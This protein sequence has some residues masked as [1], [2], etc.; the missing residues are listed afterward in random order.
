MIDQDFLPVFKSH[1]FFA[2]VEAGVYFNGGS[3]RTFILQGKGLYPLVSRLVSAMDGKASVGQLAGILP[4][5]AQP[6]FWNL[7]GQLTQRNLL[8]DFRAARDTLPAAYW[9]HYGETLAY[10]RDNVPDFSEA[11]L[12][13][14]GAPI[15]VAGSGYAF[16]ALVRA[17]ARSGVARLAILH[18][19]PD[20][21]APSLKEIT[22]ALE[23][24]AAADEEFR[25]EMLTDVR[26]IVDHPG[27]VVYAADDVDTA[28]PGA[29]LS[30]LLAE[31]PDRLL[32][33]GVAD[34]EGFVGPQ[35]VAGGG[36]VQDL[37]D[38]LR[39]KPDAIPHS[40]TS[41]SVIGN[42]LALETMRL[43]N[44]LARAGQNDDRARLND[45]WL[46]VSP[47][48]EILLRPAPSAPRRERPAPAGQKFTPPPLA[49]DTQQ[50]AFE[51]L[52]ARLTVLFDGRT[53]LFSR[54]AGD[55][56]RQIPLSLEQVEVFWPRCFGLAPVTVTGWG[57]NVNDAGVRGL[58]LAI[59]R[60]AAN[61]ETALSRERFGGLVAA[62]DEAQWQERALLRAVVEAPGVA[63]HARLMTVP[64]DGLRALLADVKRQHA[65]PWQAV[66]AIRN[67]R[68]LMRLAEIGATEPL[69]LYLAK[70]TPAGPFVGAVSADVR[71]AEGA[72]FTAIAALTEALGELCG[73]MQLD[74]PVAGDALSRW[75]WETAEATAGTDDLQA[76]SDL[77][78]VQGW[79]A[80]QGYGLRAD[81]FDLDPVFEVHGVPVGTLSLERD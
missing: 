24:Q 31:R 77:E 22:A 58:M 12:S 72:G 5:Q 3:E 15:A 27:R 20:G 13:W 56:V 62:P 29:V 8:I 25:F 18:D 60:Y 51:E 4:P 1:V 21:A 63:A 81:R 41:R 73:R 28:A 19:A 26:D 32:V 66:T 55:D 9:T 48:P 80:E 37:F 33:G 14:R 70:V 17:L 65:E 16:K 6:L 69:K 39:P 78:A 2:E 68:A 76:V 7:L 74:A 30:T 40:I 23:A 75:A 34:G 71:M 64:A 54:R 43:D 52:Q 61:L 46:H 59:E 79:L 11:F 45:W 57:L 36:S 50:S 35:S 49:A 44:G 10:F 38:R 67:A 47:G 42:L 53:G